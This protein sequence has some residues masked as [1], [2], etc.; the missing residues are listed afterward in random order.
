MSTT[1]YRDDNGGWLSILIDGKLPSKSNSYRIANNRLFKTD[2]CKAAEM[3]ILKQ[4]HVAIPQ[5]E[6]PLL[7]RG[8]PLEHLTVEVHTFIAGKKGV[9]VD[10]PLKLVLDAL[11]E[12]VYENDSQVTQCHAYR[13]TDA[14]E[15]YCII[16]VCWT[17]KA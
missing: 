14:L 16:K 13:V 12:A 3:A 7:P 15:S 2:D 17:Y 6:W 1:Y 8:C 5:K 11:Q 10:G 4:I 9:D